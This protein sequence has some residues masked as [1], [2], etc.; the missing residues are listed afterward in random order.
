MP[1][2]ELAKHRIENYCGIP[3]RRVRLSFVLSFDSDIGKLDKL[4]GIAEDIV[5]KTDGVWFGWAGFAA[6]EDHGLRYEVV[7]KCDGDSSNMKRQRQCVA[8]ELLRYVRVCI[9]QMQ[10]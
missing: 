8:H 7:I 6:F 1:N 2:T 10:S 3:Q 9:R 4:S 5:S